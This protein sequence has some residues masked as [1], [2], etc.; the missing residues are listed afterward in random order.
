MFGRH[1]T[2]AGERWPQHGEMLIINQ[3]VDVL[4]QQIHVRTIGENG[5]AKGLIDLVNPIE[6]W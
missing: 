5:V 2:L 1:Q 6:T 4:H 3:E